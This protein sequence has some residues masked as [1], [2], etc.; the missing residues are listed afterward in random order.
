MATTKNAQSA[1]EELQNANGKSKIVIRPVEYKDYDRLSLIMDQI[2]QLHVDWRPDVYKPCYPLI[3]KE[4]FE[5]ILGGNE[6]YVAEC[7]GVVAGILE[8]IERHIEGPAKVTQNIL[9]VSTIAVE[10]N[11]RGMGIGHSFF[12]MIKKMKEE[13]GYDSIELQ[14]NARNEKAIKMYREYGF[15]EKSINMELK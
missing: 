11:Y 1:N 10:E 4:A 6:W 8:L 12:D 13:K 14:V 2:Q 9:Y 7:E 15:T 5:H 3:S